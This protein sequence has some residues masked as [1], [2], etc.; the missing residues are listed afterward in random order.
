MGQIRHCGFYFYIV[1]NIAKRA[2]QLQHRERGEEWPMDR[3][4]HYVDASGREVSLPVT[5]LDLVVRESNCARCSIDAQGRPMFVS[6]LKRYV[7]NQNECTDAEIC[8]LWALPFETTLLR[9]DQAGL[10]IID[11]RLNKGS[12]QNVPHI[13]LK[14]KIE[15]S[16][17]HARWADHPPYKAVRSWNEKNRGKPGGD[18]KSDYP[19]RM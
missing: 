6:T 15:P 9:D 4:L 1:G 7:E 12:Y 5:P 2:V 8:E 3:P 18:G 19:A 10:R 11:L 16:A 14:A 17:F 13:H